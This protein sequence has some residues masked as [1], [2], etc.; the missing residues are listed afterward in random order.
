MLRPSTG[1]LLHGLRASLAETVLPALP[2]G[3]ASQ[4]LRAALHLIGRLARSWDLAPAH[5]AQDNA[6]IEDYLRG[7]LPADGPDSL[8]ARLKQARP[9]P[10]AGFNDPSLLAAAR[11]NLALHAVLAGQ[12]DSPA[13]RALH[14]RM[15]ARDAVYIGD[16]PPAEDGR[17]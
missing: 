13:L 10:P 2:K 6:D 3:A 15:A 12:P 9:A 7:T 1:D 8:A 17:A 14:Q 5:I 16:R 11:H 4:Q